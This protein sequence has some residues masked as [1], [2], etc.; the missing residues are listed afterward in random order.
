MKRGI[1][2]GHHGR[3]LRRKLRLAAALSA[4]TAGLL[5]PLAGFAHGPWPYECCHDRDCAEVDARHVVEA[6][7]EII[8]TLPAGAH[9]MAPGGGRWTTTR[10]RLRKPVTGEWGVCLS[11]TGALLCVFP[12]A[13]GG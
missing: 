8:I 3:G 7:Q 13:V 11:P 4:L 10:D 5:T 6:G 1:L 2:A 12:P 9:P